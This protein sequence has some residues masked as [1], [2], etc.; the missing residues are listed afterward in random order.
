[1][2]DEKI[3]V[4]G[5]CLS[6]GT[7]IAFDPELVPGHDGT[8]IDLAT[9]EE[10]SGQMGSGCYPRCQACVDEVNEIRADNGLEPIVVRDGAYAPT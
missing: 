7:V 1:M 4:T 3:W 6:C 2:T 8:V 10:V 9:G 5:P